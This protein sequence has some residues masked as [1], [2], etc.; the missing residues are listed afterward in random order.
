MYEKLEKCMQVIFTCLRVENVAKAKYKYCGCA[1]LSVEVNFAE[2]KSTK[3][4]YTD[5]NKLRF[6][7]LRL[8]S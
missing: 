7:I 1:L 4:S 2:I 6:K 5:D 3:N 8:R